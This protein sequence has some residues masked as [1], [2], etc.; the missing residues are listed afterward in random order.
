MPVFNLLKPTD[1]NPVDLTSLENTLATI[2]KDHDANLTKYNNLVTQLYSL[3][4]HESEQDYIDTVLK[5]LETEID[6]ATVNGSMHLAGDTI[7][8]K[9]TD[10]ITNR[11]LQQKIL[12]NTNYENYIKSVDAAQIPTATKE[13]YKQDAYIKGLNPETGKWEA[14]YKISTHID[15]NDIEK[16]TESNLVKAMKSYGDIYYRTA[17]GGYTLDSTVAS[18]SQPY[19]RENGTYVPLDMSKVRSNMK[20]S[21]YRNQDYLESL[22]QEYETYKYRFEN[23]ELT[24]N[25][26]AYNNKNLLTFDQFIEK[27]INGFYNNKNLNVYYDSVYI[28]PS[29]AKEKNKHN[30]GSNGNA[31]LTKEDIKLL[32]KEQE[33]QKE[34]ARRQGE[35]IFYDAK[36][37]IAENTTD[38][39][40]SF[41]ASRG[42]LQNLLDDVNIN[43]PKEQQFNLDYT[44][45]NS[46]KENLVDYYGSFSKV[47]IQIKDALNR[48]TESFNIAQEILNQNIK[49]EDKKRLVALRYYIDTGIRILP[50]DDDK[51]DFLLNQ[52]NKSKNA[53]LPPVEAYIANDF[54][55]YSKTTIEDNQ[56]GTIY[57]FKNTSGDLINISGDEYDLNKLLADTKVQSTKLISDRDMSLTFAGYYDTE[58]N[59][60]VADKKADQFIANQEHALRNIASNSGTYEIYASSDA[61]TPLTKRNGTQSQNIGELIN[62][63]LSNYKDNIKVYYD[64]ATLDC[65]VELTKPAFEIPTTEEQ[66]KKI[67]EDKLFINSRLSG[68]GFD[69]VNDG[70][71]TT[72]RIPNVFD[73][74]QKNNYLNDPA[75][76]NTSKVNQLLYSNLT[77]HDLN[78]NGLSIEWNN[79]ND[80]YIKESNGTKIKI[81]KQT[82]IDFYS[83]KDS[84]EM[85][86]YYYRNIPD[87]YKLTNNDINS[88]L[89][90]SYLYPNINLNYNISDNQKNNLIID[91]IYS[92]LLNYNENVADQFK[93]LLTQ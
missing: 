45:I 15:I 51:F 26:P 46:I 93:T 86:G 89:G 2:K 81:D 68:A 73:S 65:I 74:Q 37:Y 56:H 11:D 13:M 17:N 40:N 14:P 34:F 53:K 88:I 27:S 30:T 87:N 5:D 76:K 48:Y 63:Y 43:L 35:K 62:F 32:L 54:G 49:D 38:L 50:F 1:V 33:E 57:D 67:D 84:L 47:P 6:N 91:N 77:N 21:I 25:N 82:L 39:F 55:T 71:T 16:D 60:N 4:V 80:I 69:K 29:I 31:G 90:L 66:K 83:A 92:L 78:F 3:P 41:N 64:P 79:E 59:I 28:Q 52:Y 70:T 75:I 8:K 18:S 19:Y 22:K 23:G 44:D 20:E 72:V 58:S 12:N 24:D 61:N 42:Y 7:T 36:P 85:L 9:A 10:I